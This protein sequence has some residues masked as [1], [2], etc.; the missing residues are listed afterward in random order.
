MK[1]NVKH[2]AKLA[3]LELS[4]EEEEKF[5]KQ[6]GDVLSHIEELNRLSTSSVEPTAQVTQLENVMRED[7]L[8]RSLTQEEATGQA[9]LVHNGLFEVKGIFEEEG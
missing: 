9:R 3:N 7:K 6:L 1:I 2:I 5:E 8:E 4:K